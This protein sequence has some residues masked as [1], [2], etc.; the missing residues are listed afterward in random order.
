MMSILGMPFRMF[1]GFLRGMSEL[2]E[3]FLQNVL[4]G[5][6]D[7]PWWQTI[8]MLPV[9]IPYWLWRAFITAVSYPFSLNRLDPERRL[10]VYYGIP[11][12]LGMFITL[13]AMFYS[14]ASTKSIDDRY[15]AFMQRSIA[16]RDYKSATILG[17]RLVSN[18]NNVDAPTR[19]EYAV[20]LARNGEKTRSEA[21]MADLAPTDKPG[22]GPAHFLRAQALAAEVARNSN[23][24]SLANLRWHLENC[25]DE[26][27]EEVSKLWAV[28]F[29]TVGQ[30]EQAVPHLERA[31]MVNPR[32]HLSL[33]NLY[34]EIGSKPSESRALRQAEL[35]FT[36]LLA[37]DPLSM[38]DRLQLSVT[39]VR[40]NRSAE[41]E[42]LMLE[43][44]KLHND[45]EMRRAVA[46][47]YLLQF[48]INK[49]EYPNDLPTQLSLLEKAFRFDLG[50]EGVYEKM[51]EL[52]ERAKDDE[53][54]KKI[55]ATLE[56]MLVDG[57][58]T[59]L[60]HYALSSI[61]QIDGDQQQSFVHL[62]AAYQ[63]NPNI[64]VV[65]NNLA[66]MMIHKEN[67]DLA[68]ALELSETAVGLRPGDVT[69]RDTLGTI[70]MKQEKYQAA[71]A[72]F[73]AIIGQAKNKID[74]HGKLS[75]IYDKL[76]MKDL[77][78]MHA[79]K[80]QAEQEKL[81]AERR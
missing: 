74:I 2:V 26:R 51:I 52:Y 38:R 25:L 41:A 12:I 28:Y 33:A 11:A 27:S 31:S 6:T 50:L 30:P 17:G 5:M 1:L 66:W 55:K 80:V 60:V 53:E 43:G 37:D 14:V 16:V 61:Y 68:R 3:Y 10:N 13:F 76:G 65:I 49:K 40:L 20:A 77:A 7:R 9:L 72:E 19:F 35:Q 71:I 4:G 67:P 48:D 8:L 44:A 18:R 29:V 58:A 62:R 81:A 47:Y 73:E 70:Y 23:A 24:K 78:R 34:A 42:A 69:F 32:L 39:L 63:Q 46:Q 75:S 45:D 54:G 79:E 56:Q 22:Y 59:A 21:I 57:K 64:P 15:R 36:R